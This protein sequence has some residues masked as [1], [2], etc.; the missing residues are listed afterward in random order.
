M[1]ASAKVMLNCFIFKNLN[2]WT[3]MWKGTKWPLGVPS[4]SANVFSPCVGFKSTAVSFCYE[5]K[6]AAEGREKEEAVTKHWAKLMTAFVTVPLLHDT[7]QSHTRWHDW[8]QHFRGIN[9]FLFFFLSCFTLE[10]KCSLTEV[11]PNWLRLSWTGVCGQL[12]WRLSAMLQDDLWTFVPGWLNKQ[13]LLLPVTSDLWLLL[14]LP[15]HFFSF[16]FTSLF[17]PRTLNN[18]DITTPVCWNGFWFQSLVSLHPCLS[19]RWR[20]EQEAFEWNNASSED[21]DVLSP[22]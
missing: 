4:H 19:D 12:C 13:P 2:D 6:G 18:C 8:L 20:A 3:F 7:S 14:L 9:V 1:L 10:G 22:L 15:P 21:V 17:Q 5:T 16:T 11:K